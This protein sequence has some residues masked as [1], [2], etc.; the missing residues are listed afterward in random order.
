MGQTVPT[1]FKVLFLQKHSY[2][3]S[4][5]YQRQNQ[6]FKAFTV[7]INRIW[8]EFTEEVLLKLNLEDQGSEQNSQHPST[9][10]SFCEFF[11][12]SRPERGD[13]LTLYIPNLQSHKK[14]GRSMYLVDGLDSSA[15]SNNELLTELNSLLSHKC[16]KETNC[17][18]K[19]FPFRISKILFFSCQTISYLGRGQNY[20]LK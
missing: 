13:V 15:R 18:F 11:S 5:A 19:A 16:H 4:S 3:S 12:N 6:L 2:H 9:L 1:V 7:N 10:T 14:L 20:S 8:T 17:S